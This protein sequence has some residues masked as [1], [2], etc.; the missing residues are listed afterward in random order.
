[1]APLDEGDD[2]ENPQDDELLPS[3]SDSEFAAHPAVTVTEDNAA[4]Y[5]DPAA[6][7]EV[8]QFDLDATPSSGVTPISPFARPL[9]SDLDYTPTHPP[10]SPL[11]PEDDPL[12]DIDLS[13]YASYTHES[14]QPKRASK[15]RERIARRKHSKDDSSAAAARPSPVRS[16]PPAGRVPRDPAQVVTRGITSARSAAQLAVRG[17]ARTATRTARSAADSGAV[18]LD[19]Y[20]LPISR[21]GLYIIGSVIFIIT[22]VIVL[23]EIRNRP[24]EVQPNAI[25][26]GTEWTYEDNDDQDIFAL[27][28]RLREHQIGT[29]YAWVSWL[30][31]DNTWRGQ[32]NFEKVRAFVQQFHDFYPE[33]ELFGWVSF[34]VEVDQVGYRMDNEE[35]QQIIADFSRQVV[36]D[37]GFDGVFLNV[38]QVWNN[39]ENFLELLRKVRA[40]VGDDVTVSA[41]IPPDWSP[42]GAGIPVPPLI[43]PGTVWD[44][45]YKQSVALLVD[46]MTVMAYHSGLS[47]PT[48]Y[49]QW[50]AYQVSTFA[51]AIASLGGGT[52]IM[53][54]IPTFD[55]EPPGHDPAVENVITAVEGVRLGLQQAGDSADF[56]RGLALYAGWT[57]DDQEWNDFMGSWVR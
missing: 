46:Q 52:E 19:N 25:W 22:V 24:P 36:Q 27:A 40:A 38:E 30:Q 12:K 39:D 51:N 34:P 3:E 56:V 26:I 48:D 50:T 57:T 37:F 41:V 45:D 55:A 33:A 42:I 23:G 32:D 29:V 18:P 47:S 5:I 6:A 1:M 14:E 4:D 17:A 35:V 8:F 13:A 28:E 15:A 2:Y 31:P 9:E 7:D 20:K 54:G 21:T 49:T 43:V 53:I 16:A 10:A 11:S 44:T